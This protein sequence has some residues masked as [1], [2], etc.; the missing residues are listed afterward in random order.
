MTLTVS[1]RYP[2]L[3]QIHVT[4]GD[5]HLSPGSGTHKLL[6]PGA[7]RA[8]PA[9]PVVFGRRRPDMFELVTLSLY[10]AGGGRVPVEMPV[11]DHAASGSKSVEVSVSDAT[12]ADDR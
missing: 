2:T 8:E 9:C 4:L 12:T 6:R 3:G 1:L 5:V 11:A 7:Q 10:T